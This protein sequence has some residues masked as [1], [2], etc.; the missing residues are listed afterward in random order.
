MMNKK[1][2]TT[3]QGISVIIPTLNRFRYLM[4]LL[5][6]LMRQDYDVFE[7]VVID[8][9]GRA[10]PALIELV[11]THAPRIHYHAVSFK[12][13]P[14]AR[15]YGWQYAKYETMLYLDDDM[16]CE[17]D[18]LRRAV[19]AFQGQ[20]AHILG[21]RFDVVNHKDIPESQCG[22]F[23]YW[24]AEPHRGFAYQI[25]K[26]VY[27]IA[28]GCFLV[29]KQTV[30]KL[31]GFDENFSCGT[32]LYEELDFCLRAKK[33]NMKIIFDGLV[34]VTHLH[35]AQGGCRTPH[36]KE[37]V[38]SLCRNRTLIIRRHLHIFQKITAFFYLGILIFKYA[39]RYLSFACLWKGATGIC[40][41]FRIPTGVVQ[42][43]RLM[44]EGGVS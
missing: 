4:D 22:L 41:G 25:C 7:I 35:A 5:M 20:E 24:T 36:I 39:L 6:D 16:R 33:K 29:S 10:D 11:N 34:N 26:E 12:G 43:T 15:N 32:A 42:M 17:P 8:Q 14:I 31:Q 40:H 37:Y 44:G 1:L 27:H 38:Y 13:L 9:S 23:N 21:I 30:R 28:G 19:Q 2:S 18:F 3:E